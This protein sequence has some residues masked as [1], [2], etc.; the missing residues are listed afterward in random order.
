[1]SAS[2]ARYVSWYGKGRRQTWQTPRPLFDEWHAEYGFT[3]D[4][5]SEPGN[6]L[7]RKMSTADSPLPWHG[8][9]VFCNPPWS[10]IASFVELAPL[11]ELAVLLVPAR[12]NTVWWHLRRPVFVGAPH[13]SPV[14]CCLLVFGGG[15]R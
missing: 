9:R 13:N 3:L 6:G 14:D 4:G 15:G 10:D 12:V 8:E 5:A 7:L 11:A 1:M 2:A